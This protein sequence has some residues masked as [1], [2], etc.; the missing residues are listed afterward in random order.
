MQRLLEGN[1]RYRS[2]RMTR[3]NQGAKS[4]L[5]TATAQHPMAAVLTCSDSRLIMESIFDCG[6]GNLFVCRIAGNFADDSVVGSLEFAVQELGVRLLLVVG[7]ERC[8]AITAA[9]ND[10]RPPGQI[11]RLVAYARPAVELAR[12]RPGELLDNAVRANIEL[13]VQAL[14]E[15]K[16]VLSSSYD[17][18]SIV[19]RGA[20]YHLVSGEIEI[21]HF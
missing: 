17:S 19:I 8:G 3:P 14:R 5:E 21:M 18:G 4:R 1:W 10:V 6:V 9:L 16:P 12:G 20:Y 11:E 13:T 7:H 2:D 15:A